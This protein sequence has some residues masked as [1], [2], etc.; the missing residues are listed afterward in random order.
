MKKQRFTHPEKWILF[1]IPFVFIAGFILHY[2]YLWSG[3]KDFVGLISPLNES[4]WEHGKLLL[5]PTLLW[6]LVYYIAKQ[7]K[8]GIDA[9]LWF[10]GLLVAI[11]SSILSVMFF[12]YFYTQAFGF[13]SLY[14]DIF[15]FLLCSIIGPC[16]GLHFYRYSEGLG[17]LISILLITLICIL[18]VYWTFEP[19]HLPLFFDKV[20]G[21]YGI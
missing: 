21:K 7:K 6:W 16:L 13:Q 4:V 9:N 19:P 20:N 8:Y 3:Q 1:G 14:V 18:F 2:L 17:I 15:I 10:T 5:V 12:Y 11:V